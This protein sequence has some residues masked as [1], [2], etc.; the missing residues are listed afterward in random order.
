MEFHP[1][2]LTSFAHGFDD[3]RQ[4][5][6][7]VGSSFRLDHFALL[8]FDSSDDIARIGQAGTCSGFSG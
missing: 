6:G 1:Y 5:F 7:R 8:W 3:G 2:E 4:Q